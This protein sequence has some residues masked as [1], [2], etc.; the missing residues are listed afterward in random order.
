MKKQITNGRVT[1]WLLLL[2]KFNITILDRSGR[3]TLVADF[4]SR[5]H[6]EEQATLVNDDFPNKHFFFV[7]TNSPW[8]AYLANYL[9][10]GKFPQH[11]SSVKRGRSSNKVLPTLG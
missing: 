8:F 9:V 4:F 7:S 3:E 1:R 2:Q 6:N 11:L 5:I 10:I